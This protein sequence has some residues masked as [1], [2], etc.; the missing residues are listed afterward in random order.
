MQAVQNEVEIKLAVPDVA[1]VRR[2]LRQ[3]RAREV[4]PRV[5]EQ[6]TLYDTPDGGLARHGQLI[7]L[8]SEAPAAKSKRASRPAR[9]KAG[10]PAI[11]ALLTYKGPVQ[12]GNEGVALLGKRFKIREEHEVEIADALKMRSIF[13]ALGLRPLFRY[14]K[15]RTA[16]SLPRLPDVLIDLDE[17]PIGTFLEIEGDPA[18]IERA[19]ALLGYRATD[20]I[21]QSYGALYINDCR[22]RGVAP[23]DMLFSPQ[24]NHLKSHSSLDKPAHS[25]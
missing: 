7:R 14:E 13:E 20:Y 10:G 6:N 22:K 12:Q 9:A 8:R 15:Y 3:L 23:G 4:A 11:R 21:L 1:A 25:L 19:A 2:R 24:K 17:T 18:G 16:Y 5:L